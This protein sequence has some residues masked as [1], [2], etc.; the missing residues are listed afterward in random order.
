[1]ATLCF[2]LHCFLYCFY[3]PLLFA[4]FGCIVCTFW[5]CI[6]FN[7]SRSKGTQGWGQ[8]CCCQYIYFFDIQLSSNQKCFGIDF[9]NIIIILMTS[10]QCYSSSHSLNCLISLGS[11]LS[12]T[13]LRCTVGYTSIAQHSFSFLI[14][15]ILLVNNWILLLTTIESEMNSLQYFAIQDNNIVRSEDGTCFRSE[16]RELCPSD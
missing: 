7:N 12:L 1:M 14:I 16:K 9:H 3:V 11:V 8:S 13:Y 6:T 15:L 5:C 2:V 10:N 4:K